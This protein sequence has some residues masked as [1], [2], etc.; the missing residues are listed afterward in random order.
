[1]SLSVLLIALYPT[2]H[3]IEKR[4][5]SVWCNLSKPLELGDFCA[6]YTIFHFSLKIRLLGEPET[7]K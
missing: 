4:V 6:T 2:L 5:D 7:F 3:C 1:M